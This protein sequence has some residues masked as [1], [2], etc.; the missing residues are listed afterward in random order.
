MV[1]RGSLW[2][3]A[4]AEDSCTEAFED[5]RAPSRM[6]GVRKGGLGVKV[7]LLGKE[8]MLPV[9]PGRTDR[10]GKLLDCLVQRVSRCLRQVGEIKAWW[11]RGRR[12]DEINQGNL[13]M[14]VLGGRIRDPNAQARGWL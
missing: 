13:G 1:R 14:R 3:F 12:E 8:L 9:Y 11:R 7:S 2:A 6:L 5:L 4:Y 10:E